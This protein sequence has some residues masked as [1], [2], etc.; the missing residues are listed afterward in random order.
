ML[1]FSVW[2]RGTETGIMRPEVAMMKTKRQVASNSLDRRHCL[3]A[4]VAISSTTWVSCSARAEAQ[5]EPASPDDLSP[6]PPEPTGPVSVR[7]LNFDPKKLTGLS[8]RLI[9]SHHENNY[10]G[11]VR[12]LNSVEER[13][14]QLRADTPG[15]VLSALQA[16]RLEFENSV[17]LHEAY[18]DNLGGDGQLGPR[19]TSALS[20]QFGGVAAW[21]SRFEAVGASLA[22]GSG[23]ALL[24]YHLRRQQLSIDI[25]ADHTQACAD[26][27]VLLALDMYEHSYHMDFGTE[28]ARYIAAFMNNV[29]GEVVER[30]FEQALAIAQLRRPA[31]QPE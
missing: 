28:A 2:R 19:M 15:Y 30:R 29:D 7:P 22:G 3:R 25:A 23:W 16:K 21:Q 24:T 8:E 27:L 31:P 6:S 13:L 17:V 18:F 20:E 12:K 9:V 1:L 5:A 11:A 14:G 26:S 10:A 4:L